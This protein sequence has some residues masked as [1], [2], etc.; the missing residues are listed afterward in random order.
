MAAVEYTI[1]S[2]VP[3]T[4]LSPDGQSIARGYR[5]RFRDTQTGVAGD[6]FLDDDH[7]SG[8]N[9]NALIMA[10]IQAIRS[11]HGLTGE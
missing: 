1:I 11:V 5:I 10:K 3:S 7:Y 4:E 9:A 2:Q 6:V 8:V